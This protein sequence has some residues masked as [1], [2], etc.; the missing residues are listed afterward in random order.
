MTM[1]LVEANG[2]GVSFVRGS[3]RDDVQTFAYQA[4]SGGMRRKPF[5]ALRDVT[6][7]ATAG[8]ILGVVGR[9]GAG[10]TTLCRVLAGLI[11]PDT[12]SIQV[13]GD[14]S[15]LLSLGTGFDL[16]LTGRE[17]VLLNGLMLGLSRRDVEALLPEI[18]AFSGVGRFIDQPLKTYSAGMKSRLGF[19][20]GAELAPDIL[21]LDETLSVGDIDFTNRA[22][23]RLQ[24]L[25]GRARLVIL[26][27]H[28]LDFVTRYCTDALWLDAGGVRA[29]GP[30]DE[31]VR[32]YQ[33]S[34][35]R[36]TRAKVTAG[37]SKAERAEA[38]GLALAVK[39]VSVVFDLSP[40]G[41]TGVADSGSQ[42]QRALDDVSFS[43]H[44]GEV[45][46]IIGPNGAGKTTLCRVL[47]GVLKPDRGSVQLSSK[48]T[49]LLA[50]GAGFNFQLSGADNVHL[51]GMMLG[52]SRQRV[53]Q[54]FDEIVTF[55]EL[56]DVI[57][58]PV[59]HYSSG[60]RARLAF[61]TVTTIKPDV[62][63]IDEALSVG[64]AAFSRKAAAR[65]RALIDGASAVV[66]VTHNLTFV[67]SVC[68]R[69]IWLEQG[70]VIFD[71]PPDE[72]VRQYRSQDGRALSVRR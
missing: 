42:R 12:G 2:L 53:R 56:G 41:R 3:R 63:V 15:S 20:I 64:D 35:P 31:V 60:M 70:R 65:I 72:T 68:T 4:L 62:L 61:S 6:F 24:A 51:I 47:S 39:D 27:S 69:G 5:W 18:V 57:D 54:L 37:L 55:S 22:A 40:I 38:R 7:S 9:N 23:E 26:V 43:V 28:Q 46:G 71:G 34:A 48:V 32:Q 33:D 30:A 52:M 44:E 10:K 19:S 21:V 49:A 25:M 14:I 66:V 1:A 16:E 8:Q 29:S 58:E 50:L 59:K 11:K 17:N 13:R 36:V 45:V 67:E